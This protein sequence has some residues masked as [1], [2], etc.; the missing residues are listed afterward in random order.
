MLAHFVEHAH[1]HIIGQDAQ[2]LLEEAKS[3]SIKPPNAR[4]YTDVDAFVSRLKIEKVLEN[5]DMEV[6]GMD[7]DI[8]IM[9]RGSLP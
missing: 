3:F 5:V 2:K 1:K 8:R 4:T 7:G 6:L 9:I